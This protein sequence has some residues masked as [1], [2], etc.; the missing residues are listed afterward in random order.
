MAEEQR[1][2]DYLRGKGMVRVDAVARDCL[3]GATAEWVDRVVANLDWL[4]YV[5]VY[6]GS[7]GGPSALQLTDMALAEAMA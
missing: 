5:V 4:G 7:D 6:H 3:P 2:I 1:M